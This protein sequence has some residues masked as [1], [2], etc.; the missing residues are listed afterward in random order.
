MKSSSVFLF[1][2]FVS[3]YILAQNNPRISYRENLFGNH[4]YLA[5]GEKVKASEIEKIMGAFPEDA[6]A[7]SKANQKMALSAMTFSH[8]MVR[9]FFIEQLY[10]GFTILRNE[11]YHHQ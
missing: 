10:R 8:Q 11:P 4:V 9:L 3:H 7:F 1:L 2:L 6:E 5:D